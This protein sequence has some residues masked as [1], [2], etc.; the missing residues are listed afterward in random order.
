MIGGRR[1]GFF[2][3][4]ARCTDGI[5]HWWL[6]SRNGER[7]DPTAGQFDDPNELTHCYQ[8]GRACGFLTVK[9]SRRARTLISRMGSS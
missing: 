8:T 4:V 6:Q 7:L 3:H 1:S 9:P 5:T 2:P